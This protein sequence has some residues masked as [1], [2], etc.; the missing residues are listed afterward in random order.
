[1]KRLMRRI[2][3]LFAELKRR[4]LFKVVAGYAAAAFVALQVAEATFEPLGLPNGAMIGL[5]IAV[6]VGFPITFI[7]AWIYD[8]TPEGI[9]KTLPV[10]EEA[11]RAAAA[12]AAAV[13]PGAAQEP[14]AR[15][16][17]GAEPGAVAHGA[18]RRRRRSVAVLVL[19]ILVV[20]GFGV[21]IGYLR[22]GGAAAADRRAI[23][24]LPFENLSP[25]AENAFFSDG[26]TEE[27]LTAL[28]ALGELRV[29]SRTTVMAYRGTD[30]TAREI[31]R[32]L[33]VGTILEGSVRRVGNEVRI[34]AQLID[35]RTDK[36]LWARSYH[37]TMDDIFRLQSEI[38]AEIAGALAAELSRTER[39]RLARAPTADA[40]AF[41]AYVR[42]RQL[43]ATGRSRDVEEAIALLEG[44][45]A[46]DPGFARAHAALGGAL[47]QQAV[48]L[49]RGE[50]LD[51]AFGAVQ[52][53]LA[54][55][56]ATA[57][58]Y[59]VLGALQLQKGQTAAAV[60]AYERALRLQ[61][62][63]ADAVAGMGMA[64]TARGLP[65][66]AVRAYLRARELEPTSPAHPLALATAH[67]LL[68]ELDAA[69]AWVREALRKQEDL[70]TAHLLLAQLHLLRGDG[71]G[72]ARAARVMLRV[73]GDEPRAQRAAGDLALQR[74]ELAAAKDHYHRVMA[75][76]PDGEL[77]PTTPLAWIAFQEGDLER[78][79][80]YL[81]ASGER[82]RTLSWRLGHEAT[83][84]HYENARVCAIVGDVGC[85]LHS[86]HAAV[87]S[88]F[89]DLRALAADPVLAPIRE[90]EGYRA[91]TQGLAA[92]LAAM[93]GALPAV[94]AS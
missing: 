77:A 84:L 24:V 36:H 25:D 80:D 74:G 76:A 60:E 56:T 57:E 45:I 67:A 22:P 75:A 8:I 64:L 5:I 33:G 86:L 37:R 66:E 85:A 15:T 30:K 94:R 49:G 1:M 72:A 68:G 82:L 65:G 88:G 10:E 11:A 91:L 6:V 18:R 9:R 52:R 32:E 55:D 44:A 7:L 31:G 29:V 34:T 50:R 2:H 81:R 70:W 12:R 93:R 46:V 40:G 42:G 35:A 61:P 27:L 92:E 73:A 48:A 19:G 17:P 39:A 23:A 58:A 43:L 3:R 59:E 28:A 63:S 41:D 38:A 89:R 47:L 51:A 26:I 14:P 71:P 78:G 83:R 54:L 21:S 87:A 4:H 20:G 53:A 13:E 79:A 69:E 16:A 62:N 90:E